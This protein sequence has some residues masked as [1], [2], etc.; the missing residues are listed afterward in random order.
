MTVV[1]PPPPWPTVSVVLPVRNGAAHL[2][3]AVDAVLAQDY[4]GAL[5]VVVAVGP[6]DDD[7]AGVARRVAAGHRRV[8]VVDN[9]SGV[10][11]AGLNRATAAA[12]GSVVARV[13][14]HAELTPGYLRRA[15]ELLAET[16]AG[17]VGGIQRAVGTGAF[18]RAVAAAMTSPYGTGDARFHY[19]GPPG[20]TDTVYLGVFRRAAL[21]EVGGFDETLVRNQDYELNHRLRGA[22][23]LVWFDPDLEVVYRPRSTPGALAGQYFQYGQWKR[24]V[25]RR[26]PASLRWRQVVAPAAVVA[27]VAGAL[28][29]LRWRGLLAVPAAYLAAT[30]AAALVEQRRQHLDAATT[31]R[32]PVAFAVMH[33]SWGLGAIVGV[34]TGGRP[35]S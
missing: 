8:T 26:A 29:G 31:A 18:Q 4:P 1:D 14:A 19:G 23:W 32:L 28:A 2:A 7:T 30:V 12:T 16:G 17:N 6:S 15:V 20:P 22:G 13:D 9:P 33:H 10:T 21:D 34:R 27:N 5:E 3:A 11:P 35:A 24:E 25:V